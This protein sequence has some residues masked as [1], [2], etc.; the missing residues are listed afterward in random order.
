MAVSTST[1]NDPSLTY[2]LDQFINMKLSDNIT[3]KN[4]SISEIVDGIELLDHNLI[5]D[6]LSELESMCVNVPL[7]QDQY[8]RY[9]YAPDLLAYDVYGSTQLDFIVLFAN[10]II[11]PKEFDLKTIK[12]PYAKALDTF[13]NSI[14]SSE[15]QY[16]EYNNSINKSKL[17]S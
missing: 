16:L 13:L 7:E 10:G 8:V 11:D 6:Y 4:F 17:N 9:K 1:Y 14:Y 12:L 5:T 15:S 2:T 3:Y